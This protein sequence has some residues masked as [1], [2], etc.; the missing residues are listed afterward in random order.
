M[1]AL[2]VLM[3]LLL[4]ACG[5]G[6]QSAEPTMTEPPAPTATPSSRPETPSPQPEE[7]VLLPVLEKQD[8][9]AELRS[10]ILEVR[11]PRPMEVSQVAFG[12][13]P[14]LDV[15][16]LYNDLMGQM[17]DLKYAYAIS[18]V[19]EQDTLNCQISYMPYKTGQYP[20]GI[21]YRS[22]STLEEL[23]ATAEANLG[24]EPVP[25]RIT[26]PAL[27]P[28]NLNRALQQVGGGYILCSLKRDGTE[29]TYRPAM[30]MTME[31][32]LSLLEEADQLADQVIAQV[33]TADMTQREQAEA[34]YGYITERVKYDQRYYSD[35]EN[36]PY[37][38]Q[39]AIGALRDNL[40]I[41][42]GYSHAVKLLFEKVDIPCYNVTGLYFREHHMWNAALLDGEWLWFDATS[43]RGSTPEFGFRHFALPALD[44]TQYQWDKNSVPMLASAMG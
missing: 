28:D 15:I 38:A 27:T 10:A 11:Q 18:P 5:G 41:C 24:T 20:D 37:D 7:P 1:A 23:I 17:P 29:L 39:T 43:D 12:E 30:G 44:A 33:V 14:S 9:Q 42:G 22:V 19:F 8:I 3:L 6:T 40:A 2:T 31:Q 32:C 25:I 21:S 36:M 35:R 13:E 4:C 26:D 16:N 34:L